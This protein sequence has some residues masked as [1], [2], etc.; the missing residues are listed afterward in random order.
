[1][2]KAGHMA[3]FI[4]AKAGHMAGFI[5][6]KSKIKRCRES[7]FTIT[8]FNLILV[9]IQVLNSVFSLS[10]GADLIGIRV[11]K[12][13]DMVHAHSIDD[14]KKLPNFFKA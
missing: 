4:V 2:A 3:G 10:W 14:A 1:V 11:K 13:C 6:A 9:K 5:V 12:K 7:V 8:N